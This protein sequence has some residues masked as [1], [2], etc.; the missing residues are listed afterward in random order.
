MSKEVLLRDYK[1]VFRDIGCLQE[2][3]DIIVDQSIPPVQNEP[4]KIP[5]VMRKAVTEKLQAMEK[6]GLIAKVDTPTP[7]ISNLTAVSA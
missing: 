7:W 6:E 5:H 2:E 1:D 4:R 3:Y